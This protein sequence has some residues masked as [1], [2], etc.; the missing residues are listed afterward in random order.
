MASVITAEFGKRKRRRNAILNDDDATVLGSLKASKSESFS[1]KQQQSKLTKKLQLNR[2]SVDFKASHLSV[3]DLHQEIITSLFKNRKKIIEEQLNVAK[4]EKEMESLIKIVK[5][6]ENKRWLLNKKKSTLHELKLLEIKK[7]EAKLGLPLKKFDKRIKPIIERLFNA[8]KSKRATIILEI[9][10][11]ARNVLTS[12]TDAIILQKAAAS[13]MCE[14]CGISMRLIMND[15][16]LGC[17]QCAKT[18]I[19]TM[20]SAPVADSEYVSIPYPQKSRLVEWLEFCQAKEY[21]EPCENILNTVMKQLVDS[22][23]TGLERYT[24]IISKERNKGGP[25]IDSASSIERLKAEIPQIQSL[26]LGIKSTMVRAAM[27][28]ASNSKADERLRKFYE[29]SPKYAAYISGYWPLRF[30]NAQEERIKALYAVAMP[31]YEKYRKPSQPNWPGGY[32]YFLRCIC[33]LLGWDEFINHFSITSGQKNGQDREIVREQIW[34]Q[35][36]NWEFVPNT[37]PSFNFLDSSSIKTNLNDSKIIN[38]N[39]GE[40]R[41][42]I[43][44][45]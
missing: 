7:S 38:I 27:Q 41:K 2:K 28:N 22:G 12:P 29:R 8:N 39:S 35:Y 17:P 15:S 24:A 42:R 6:C 25:F 11:E 44:G 45:T 5:E 40:K 26:L 13:D 10:R 34:K 20:V 16:L 14:S 30:T 33:V 23:S 4:I 9:E 36:L 43:D 37:P 3:I 1:P 19:I 18:K 31:A 32:A 21:A